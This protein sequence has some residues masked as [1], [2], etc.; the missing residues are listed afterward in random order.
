MPE[1]NETDI[2]GEIRVMLGRV[3]MGVDEFN[4]FSAEFVVVRKQRVGR[5]VF[6]YECQVVLDNI[7]RFTISDVSLEM[8]HWSENI[9]IIDPNVTFDDAQV[10]PGESI[11]SA[12]TC[13]FTVDRSQPIDAAE[14]IWRVSAE[15]ADT[16]AKMQHTVSI[17]LPPDSQTNIDGLKDLAEKWLWQGTP[18]GID[19]DSV[20]DGTVNLADFAKL[21]EEWK[22]Q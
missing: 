8:A 6:E 20:P 10:G 5:T 19:A 17:T 1:P 14:I 4:P 16:G 7:S 13:T 2:D 21:A 9:T 3:D 22:K 15:L 18:G 11:A 12:D